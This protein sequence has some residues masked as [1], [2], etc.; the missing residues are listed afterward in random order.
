MNGDIRSM[1]VG[2]S[3]NLWWILLVSI[4]GAIILGVI[5]FMIYRKCSTNKKVGEEEKKLLE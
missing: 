2:K 5:G 3:S 1:S 4:G